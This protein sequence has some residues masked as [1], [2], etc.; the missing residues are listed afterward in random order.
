MDAPQT[1]HARGADP[2]RRAE[3]RAL[4][5]IAVASAILACAP[6]WLRPDGMSR[7]DDWLTFYAMRAM[8]R[9]AVVEH[10]EVPMWAPWVGGG[11]P[12]AGHPEFPNLTPFVLPTLIVGE[13]V[14]LKVFVSV[15][16]LIG[17]LGMVA[18]T[19]GTLRMGAAGAAV[20]T[21]AFTLSGYLPGRVLSGNP[22]ELYLL[23]FPLMLVLFDRARRG[24]AVRGVAGLA[25]I[26]ALTFVDGKWAPG[27]LA[28]ML[29]LWSLTWLVGPDARGW[30]PRIRP[31]TL[32]VAAVA[33]AMPLA[34]AKLLPFIDLIARARAVTP[35]N[36]SMYENVN[37]LNP[38]RLIEELAIGWPKVKYMLGFVPLG[39][40]G[41]SA[42]RRPRRSWR[43]LVLTGLAVWLMIGRHAP[44]DLFRLLWSLPGFHNLSSSHIPFGLFAILGLSVLAGNGA[45][46][47]LA[48]RSARARAAAAAVLIALTVAPVAIMAWPRLAAEFQSPP[49]VAA[50]GSWADFR[51]VRTRDLPRTGEGERPLEATAYYRV[52]HHQGLIDWRGTVLM[53][54]EAPIAAQIIRKRAGDERLGPGTRPVGR[55]DAFVALDNREYP[56]AEGWCLHGGA[57]ALTGLTAN[58]ITVHVETAGPDRLVVNQNFHPEWRS[59]VGEVVDADGLIG[60]DLPDAG[61][62]T[63]RLSFHS[64]PFTVGLIISLAAW[65]L[66]AAGVVLD[67]LLRRRRARRHAL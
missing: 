40:A 44:F 26:L 45:E 32:A 6:L 37:C 15:L 59:S 56:G 17:A 66:L 28:L 41:V 22:T 49:I 39:L 60:V 63:V 4:V 1:P 48:G 31:V 14:G 16:C 61:R 54:E 21:C 51:Q 43:W 47:L 65:A 67:L 18:L 7:N 57:V 9:V 38:G 11:Y 42:V 64:R 12:I 8:V 25:A 23:W 2:A 33:A 5:V 36:P 24:R 27:V 53:P 58:T 55:G 13:V 35:D 3:R 50:R 10:G 34:A 20:A 29:G 30:R 46:V 52:R 62:R 19:H